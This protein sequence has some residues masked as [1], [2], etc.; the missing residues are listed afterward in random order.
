VN[1]HGEGMSSRNS[2][3]RGRA[4]LH[5]ILA[6]WLLAGTGAAS[7]AGELFKCGK[8]FQDRP[9]ESENVQ[10]RFSRTQGTFAIQQV[11]PN[12]DHGCAKVAAEAMTWWERLARGESMDKLQ[13]E[14][15]AQKTSRYDKSL[16]RD[17]LTLIGDHRGTPTEVRS[18]F[19]VQC[20]AYKRKHG[21][22]GE[23]DVAG[24]GTAGTY[25]SPSSEAA[26]R[27]AEIA[28][29]RA[30]VARARAEAARDRMR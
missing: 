14:I 25:A 30:A 23:R 13:A 9:C 16:L 3:R 28:A 12:T 20:M 2:G 27:R 4:L 19:E 10:Q 26:A 11:N 18:Q 1:I 8:T 5:A 17:T 7:Q 15:Q 24:A 22:P 29:Q 6:A 21:Y